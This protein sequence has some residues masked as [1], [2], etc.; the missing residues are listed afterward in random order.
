LWTA[1]SP[2]T[3]PTEAAY[4]QQGGDIAAEHLHVEGA[5][6]HQQSTWAIRW[7]P[8]A[9]RWRPNAISLGPGTRLH[10]QISLKKARSTSNIFSHEAY[11]YNKRRSSI[12]CDLNIA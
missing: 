1:P 10:A 11:I 9:A 2:A 7:R 12:V 5:V 4:V 6:H 3:A 8:P